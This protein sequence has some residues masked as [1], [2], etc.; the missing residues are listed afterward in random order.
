MC[1]TNRVN[2]K[3]SFSEIYKHTCL[4]TGVYSM[5]LTTKILI[6]YFSLSL[7]LFFKNIKHKI[8]PIIAISPIPPVTTATMLSIDIISLESDLAKKYKQK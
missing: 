7:A 4:I 2:F 1:L 8:I 6:M 3:N 5:L